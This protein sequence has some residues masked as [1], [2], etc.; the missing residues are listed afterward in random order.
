MNSYPSEFLTQLGPVM[1]IAGLDAPSTQQ[2]DTES[3]EDDRIL[4]KQL[5]P[6]PFIMLTKRLRDVLLEK[7]MKKGT[8]WV[9]DTDRVGPG[10]RMILVD[11]V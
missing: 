4:G 1:F 8:I 6:D 9:G 5:Q 10:F 2:S 7:S 11:K 3:S